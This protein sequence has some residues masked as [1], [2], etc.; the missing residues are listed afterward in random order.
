MNSYLQTSEN[1]LQNKYVA[2]ILIVLFILYG[3][4]IAPKL[5]ISA[6]KLFENTFFRLFV[7]FLIAYL[8]SANPVIAVVAALAVF[9]SIQAL[10]KYTMTEKFI[11]N[12]NYNPASIEYMTNVELAHVE[13]P[14]EINDK[15][16]VVTD[17]D[18]Q[19]VAND[20]NIVLAKPTVVQ[21]DEGE[22]V[23]DE[24]GKVIVVS[25]KAAVD[26]NGDIAKNKDGKV[27]VV[28]P[29]IVKDENN[30]PVKN[31]EGNYMTVPCQVTLQDDGSIY[32]VN[33][34][35]KRHVKHG[36]MQ[37]MYG[38]YKDDASPNREED[39][40]MVCNSSGCFDGYDGGN[41]LASF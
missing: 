17:K 14:M 35:G 29:M 22:I 20:G 1:F 24:N 33:G 6:A 32:V 27:I 36:R 30:I 4:V 26:E 10:N 15:E 31:I 3:S 28:P 23:K 16:K 11:Q 13:T 40:S 41:D 34:T 25:P 12:M 18:G 39:M 7:F 8:A 9:L 21:D 37:G 19:P 2:T 5:P 38:V